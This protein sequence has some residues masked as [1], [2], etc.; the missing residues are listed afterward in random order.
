MSDKRTSKTLAGDI[1]EKVRTQILSGQ[2]RAG[3]PL[4]LMALCEQFS[5]SL[6]IV[7]E[8]LTRLATERL[9]R[10]RPQQGFTV[11]ALTAEEMTDV[12]F[13]RSELESLAL[14]RS[15]QLGGLDWE[16]SLIA[17][18]HKLANTPV[19]DSKKPTQPS[20]AYAAA[21][22]EFHATLIGACESPT[23]IEFC[24]T[25]YDASELYRRMSYVLNQNR[26]SKK[27][28]D[29]RAMMDAALARDADLAVKILKAHYQQTTRSLINNSLLEKARAA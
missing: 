17:A 6:T 4:R 26:R 3:Q 24:R 1:Y 21:H 14:R 22:A 10:A 25:L 2:L 9:V 23:L 15:I 16:A 7:R 12:T 20:D 28:S 13:V 19:R 8:A 29:H 27:F 11:A 18:H 5:V